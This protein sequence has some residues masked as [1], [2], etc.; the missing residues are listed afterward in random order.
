MMA[1]LEAMKSD[2]R[3]I[4]GLMQYHAVGNLVNLW[5]KRFSAAVYH[6][7]YN[8]M[9]ARIQKSIAFTFSARK[10]MSNLNFV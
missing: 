6:H 5:P 3:T 2:N 8:L 7:E 4:I 9:L 1:A 10:N